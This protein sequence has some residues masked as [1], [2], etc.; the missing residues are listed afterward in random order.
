MNSRFQKMDDTE[1]HRDF[2]HDEE[3]VACNVVQ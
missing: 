3:H 1:I 2:C